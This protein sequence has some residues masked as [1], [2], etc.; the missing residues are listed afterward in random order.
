M[1]SEEAFKF[2]VRSNLFTM[3][4]R[5]IYRTIFKDSPF[6][7][8]VKSRIA[9]QVLYPTLQLNCSPLGESILTWGLLQTIG[10][11]NRRNRKSV[12]ETGINLYKITL[13]KIMSL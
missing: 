9:Y 8:P 11:G 6:P 10:K 1:W 5:P 12:G 13:H 4:D 7:A 3:I 2:C